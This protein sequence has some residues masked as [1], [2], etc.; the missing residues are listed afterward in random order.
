M[1]R[2]RKKSSFYGAE[3]VKQLDTFPKVNKDDFV[4]RTRFGGTV[5]V[6]AYLLIAWIL[7][8]ETSY[9]LESNVDF[10]F[11]PDPECEA[12]LTLNIDIVVATPCHSVGADILDSTHENMMKFGTLKQEDTWFEMSPEQIVHFNDIRHFNTYLREEFHAINDVLWKSRHTYYHKGLPKREVTPNYAP[13]ACRIYG[14]LVLNKVAGNLH[15][16]IGKSIA[17][18]FNGHVHF[19]G[20]IPTSQYNFSHRI[21]HLSFGDTLVGIINPLD[22]EEKISHD[23]MALYQYFIEVVPTDVQTF[24]SQAKTYQFSVKDHMRVINHDKGSH[25]VP[26]IF[27]KYDFSALKVVVTQSHEPLLKFCLRLSSTMAGIFVTAGI[28]KNFIQ[29]IMKKVEKS[30]SI[31]RK[32]T[33]SDKTFLSK[34]DESVII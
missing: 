6:I 1:L 32:Y 3:I 14:S 19:S 18:P 27:F 33:T 13:D 26:G 15:V 21:H 34:E 8:R 16:T 4:E 22:S 23:N 20:L 30:F 17:L 31:S 9:Y 12:K 29:Y 25:G 2:Q 11:M 7:V 28:L 24:F 5:T 10:K